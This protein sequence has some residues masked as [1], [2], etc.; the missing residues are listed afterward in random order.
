KTQENTSGAPE[1]ADHNAKRYS[2]PV[3]S[4]SKITS[5]KNK[6]RISKIIWFYDDN[7]FEE[8]FPH[9]V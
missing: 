9:I 4:V 2:E 5:E 6:S 7:S 8:F 1:K 3:D